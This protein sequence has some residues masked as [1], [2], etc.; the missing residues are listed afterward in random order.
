MRV[1]L[2]ASW[3]VVVCVMSSCGPKA[4]PVVAPQPPA[5]V[6]EQKMRWILQLEDE[7]QLRGHGG[8][9]VALL[10]DPEARVRRRAALAVGR[11]RL[12]EGIT[13]L[14][15]LLQS[16]ADPEVRQMAAFAMGLIG[17]AAAAPAL[18]TALNDADPL[19]Q[20]RAAE[21]LGLIA[22]KEAAQ[23]ITNMIY[24][25]VNGG[26][27]NGISADDMA[28]PKSSA[29]DA[30]RLG[31]YALVRLGSYDGLAS[32]LLDREG[33]PRSRWWP[34]AFAFQRVNDARAAGVL[35]DLFGGDGQLTRA[36]AARGLGA[37]K[38]PRA[39]APMLAAA[40]D[41][42]QPLAVRIQAVRALAQLGDAR[43]GAVMRRLITSAK[44]DQNLQLEAITALSQ[45]RDPASVELLIDLVSAA[46]P[47]VRA[48]SLNAL[49]RTDE[50]TFIASISALDPDPHWSVRA[51]LARTL[52]DLT[53][54]R[55]EAPLMSMLKDQD[56][57]VIP[58]VL[59][60][61]AKVGAANAAQEMLTRLNAEDPV[62]RAA[63]ARGLATLKAPNAAAPLVAALKTAQS[64]GLYVTRTAILEAL[65]ALDPAAAKPALTA[66]LGDRDWAVRM[67]AAEQLRRLDASANV[68]AMRPAPAPAIPEL[69]AVDAMVSPQYS[70]Q[71][72]IDTS[73][74]TIQFE[75]AVLDA[76]RTVANFI[77]LARKNY[78]RGVQL[79]RVVPDFVVQDGDPRG[80]GEGSPGYTIRDEINQR[81][82]LRGTVGMALDW[83]DTGGSQFFITHS[84]QPHLD[85]RYTV[86]GQV[87]SGMDVID[88]LQQ[89]DT[90]ER[91]RVWD[92][93]NW[94]G[95][96]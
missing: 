62:V 3:L 66:A 90:I 96:D 10:G 31:A 21:A 25:H 16:D 89:W 91:I 92:G 68:S 45:I 74:G 1:S 23:P 61:L 60:A 4:E 22:H 34:I 9:L 72:Y 80:D 33:R 35:L 50:D 26:A 55:A 53:R 71:A 67:R 76:P 29:V 12:P 78:F 63:A 95:Q 40:E 8:D 52:G 36:F 56:Q 73:K 32:A 75:L 64:D 93:V 24:A 47:S 49:A 48:A 28:V 13:G 19:I 70:P 38:D 58:A 54:E 44:V 2:R 77:A 84:P 57:R 30:V 85:G 59:D 83:A 86:F 39:V 43:A 88:R 42:G 20:G 65:I 69:A 6:Y 37:S 82:Y 51:A 81:P 94:I 5:A 7:R 46:W 11:V 15:T 79:H 17:D 14:T 18:M 27:L 87:V 41:A